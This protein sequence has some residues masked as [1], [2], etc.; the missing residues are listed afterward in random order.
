[1]V[2]LLEELNI[3]RPDAIIIQDWGVYYLISKYFKQNKIHAS[4]QM[5]VHNSIGNEDAKNRGFERVVLARELTFH[6]LEEVAKKKTTQLELFIHGSLCYSMSGH[7]LFSSYLGGMSANRGLCKQPCRR[8]FAVSKEQHYLFSLKDLQLIDYIPEIIDLGIESLK[9]EGRMKSADYVYNTARAY[10][11][12]IDD[13]NRIE[14]AK[15]ILNRDLARDKTAYFMGSDIHDI[16]SSP[17]VGGYLG[18]VDNFNASTNSDTKISFTT[19]LYMHDYAKIR[20]ISDKNIDSDLIEI[21]KITNKDEQPIDEA[22]AGEMINI[23]FNTKNDTHRI[24]IDDEIYLVSDFKQN[25]CKSLPIKKYNLTHHNAIKNKLKKEKD[26]IVSKSTN[27]E[28]FMRIDNPHWLDIVQKTDFTYLILAFTRRMWQDL[29]DFTEK[30]DMFKEHIVIELPLFMAEESIEH[31]AN[32]IK[33][34]YQKGFRYFSISQI[35]QLLL[36]KGYKDIKIIANENIYALNDYSIKF[37]YENNV[38]R[39][40]Y[41]FENDFDNLFTGMDRSGIIPLFFYPKLFFSRMPVNLKQ[42]TVFSDI[43]YEYSKYVKD[44]ITNIVSKN[45]VSIYHY[46]DKVYK[47]GFKRFLTDLSLCMPTRVLYN[48]IINGYYNADKMPNSTAFNF[49]K[50]LW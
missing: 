36:L 32:L 9:I 35:N 13:N 8:L 22:K 50:G 38:N 29:D 11:M 7:C 5:G 31:W 24:G 41:P 40:I 49:K 15:N 20:I 44:G 21:K 27:D 17:T 3:M 34:Y 16:F 18:K 26:S 2:D 10:R 14:E 39:F 12:A 25:I 19:D 33:E 48:Q 1:M 30:C 28:H 23:Y 43:K 6:E 46:Y 47:K 45:P 37:L 4:T 42:N